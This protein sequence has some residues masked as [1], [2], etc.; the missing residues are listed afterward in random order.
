MHLLNEWLPA[1][2]GVVAKLEHGS[3]VADVGCGHGVTTTL[4][5]KAFP[6]STF[7]GFDYHQPSLDRATAAAREAGVAGNLSFQQASAKD[8]AWQIRLS[9][10][11][12]LP[13]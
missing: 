10:L 2:D 13:A 3:S 12:R 8:Y 4:M 6:R 7:T 1:L 5:A 11:L 9:R